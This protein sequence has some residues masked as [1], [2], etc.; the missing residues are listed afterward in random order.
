MKTKNPEIKELFLQNKDVFINLIS[1]NYCFKEDLLSKH[2]DILNW[3]E[4][5]SNQSIL[6]DKNLLSRFE[7]K[8]DWLRFSTFIHKNFNRAT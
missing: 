8:W 7:N 5:S 3:K 2:E 1:K 6:H 4:L